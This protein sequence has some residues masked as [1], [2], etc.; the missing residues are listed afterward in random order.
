MKNKLLVIALLLVMFAGCTKDDPE[1]VLSLNSNS[2]TLFSNGS[3][4]LVVNNATTEKFTYTSDNSLIAS[5]DDNGLITGERVGETTIKVSGTGFNGECKVA[6]KPLYNTFV[7][8]ITTFGISKSEVKAKETRIIYQESDNLIVYTGNVFERY[9]VYHF[10][11]GK[12]SSSMIVL[13]TAYTT[14]LGKY[15][16]E[17]YVV[18]SVSPVLALGTSKTF[19]VGTSLESTSYWAVLYF[20]YDSTKSASIKSHTTSILGKFQSELLKN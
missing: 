5:V 3:N 8:P 4:Q 11:N 17:R 10:E 15:I 20:P 6:I 19:A 2:I 18:V 16:A 12:L 9:A 7:E 14:E 13:S 1:P